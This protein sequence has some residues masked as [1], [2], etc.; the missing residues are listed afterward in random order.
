MSVNTRR[1][2]KPNE[3]GEHPTATLTFREFGGLNVQSPRQSIGDNQFAWLENVMPIAPGNMPVVYA[4]SGPLASLR[5]VP[6]YSM[7]ANF[8]GLNY[9]FVWGY[10]GSCYQ[11]LLS[12]P[13]TVTTVGVAGTFSTTVGN[14]SATPYNAQ[15][16][17]IIDAVKG[18]F[19]WGVTSANALTQISGTVVSVTVTAPGI[20]FT[21]APTV[22]LSGGGGLGGAVV[23]NITPQVFT[24]TA[25][26]TGYVIG[27]VLTLAGGTTI[28]GGT[29]AKG[30]VIVTATSSGAVTS[31]GSYTPGYYNTAPSNPVSVTGGHG[32]GATLTLN[33]GVAVNGTGVGIGGA[34]SGYTS[35]PVATITGGG[36]SGAAVTVN[37]N[38]AL[39][40]TAVAVYAGRVWIANN[41]TISYTDVGSYNS[42]AGAGGSFTIQDSTLVGAITAL[43]TTNGFLYI[44]GVTSVDAL[45]NV[46]VNTV[47]VTSFT[48]V[49]ISPSIGCN[50]PNSIFAYY[51]SILFA[52]PSGFY[53]LSGATPQKISDDL[54][55]IVEVIYPGNPIYGGQVQVFGIL[56]AAFL[57]V[58]TDNFVN[59]NLQRAILAVFFRGKWWLAAQGSTIGTMVSAP[60]A[61]ASTLF[62]FTGSSLI[63]LFSGP[64]ALAHQWQTKLWDGGE[65]ILSKQV[66]RAGLG[67]SFT[68]APTF[69]VTTDNEYNSQPVPILANVLAVNW[70]N[71]S[72]T[73]VAWTNTAGKTV[74]WTKGSGTS[75][76]SG[77]ATTAG[78]KYFGLTVQS[79]SP[80]VIYELAALE[81]K[82]QNRWQ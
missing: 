2:P 41:R 45:S 42:F 21:S 64:T 24:V 48:R 4:P 70:V 34:G 66:I 46:Q 36:G 44:F 51:R 52:N 61:G 16:I 68:G 62:G 74:V 65:P 7:T 50:Q 37:I 67:Y 76:D 23:L 81:Y 22:A 54:D 14:I 53:S 15:G 72:N 10:D 6:I 79:S 26:G 31:V 1:D 30:T 69:T 8:N 77:A 38:G 80:S 19:D 33:W 47:D 20:N 12:S 55:G 17:L 29:G 5:A 63:Q 28:G 49:N 59:T 39:T 35:S 43:F 9:A 11:I 18:Y 25:G 40:G 58:F 3:K 60:V 82:D 73:Q 78:G 32:S 27:D 56:C 57:F 71:A 75:L 13:Y